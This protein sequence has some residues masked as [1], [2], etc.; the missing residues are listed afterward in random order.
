MIFLYWTMILLFLLICF[1][2]IWLDCSCGCFV[3][4]WKSTCGYKPHRQDWSVEFHDTALA[5]TMC[6]VWRLVI[7]GWQAPENCPTL[8]PQKNNCPSLC[9]HQKYWS[10]ASLNSAVW[11]S[12]ANHVWMKVSRIMRPLGG[13]LQ[14]RKSTELGKTMVDYQLVST[15]STRLEGRSLLMYRYISRS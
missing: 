10:L 13:I 11:L 6:V 7:I 1:R 12:L 4:H 2:N 9:Q 5:G 14:C 3:F 8:C 15:W